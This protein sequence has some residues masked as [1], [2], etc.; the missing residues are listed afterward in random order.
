MKL[1]DILKTV[2]AGIIREAVPGGGLLLGLVNDFLP[3][4]KKLGES[5]TASDVKAAIA[6][7]APEDQAAI[8][9]KEIDVRLEEIKQPHNSLRTMLDNEHTSPH[10]TRP[11]IALGA[12]QVTAAVTLIVVAMWA[13][14]VSEGDVKTIGEVMDGWPFIITILAP[15]VAILRAYFGMLT[16]EHEN[17]SNAVNGFSSR[18]GLG[19]IIS[20]IKK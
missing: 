19:A 20:A 8:M 18:S 1:K 4:D 2:G 10:T 5:A 14:A 7:M 11:K 6:T 12:F 17:R 13:V 15:F 16:K 3:E 9:E